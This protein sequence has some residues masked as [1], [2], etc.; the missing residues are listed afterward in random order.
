MLIEAADL[1]LG[2]ACFAARA[3]END[4]PKEWSFRLKRGEAPV[5]KFSVIRAVSPASL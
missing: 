2:I 4:E 1:A 5:K 3:P